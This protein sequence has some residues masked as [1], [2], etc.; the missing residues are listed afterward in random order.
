M[1]LSAYQNTAQL[2]LGLGILSLPYPVV[3]LSL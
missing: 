3:S 2:A 1:D